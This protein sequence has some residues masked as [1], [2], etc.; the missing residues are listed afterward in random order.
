MDSA[1]VS[2]SLNI[3]NSGGHRIGKCEAGTSDFS[4]WPYDL[5]T[6]LTQE[7]W[8]TP[9]QGPT[10]VI[11]LVQGDT[12]RLK[13]T[14]SASGYQWYR[15]GIPL[16]GENDSIYVPK[17]AATYTVSVSGQREGSQSECM[18]FSDP[19][20]LESLVG[21]GDLDEELLRIYPNPVS[22][23]LRIDHLPFTTSLV[24]YTIYSQHGAHVRQGMRKVFDQSLQLDVEALPAGMYYLLIEAEGQVLR[25]QFVK[26]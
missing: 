1:G 22:E 17:A 11:T 25:G 23:Q 20:E 18:I 5:D 21:I 14:S 9:C 24:K 13:T 16:S 7:G 10:P 4:R 2:Y 26:E 12:I 8:T 3:Y 6:W 19:L 15:N